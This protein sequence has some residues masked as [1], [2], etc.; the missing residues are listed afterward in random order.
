MI[1][2]N[3]PVDDRDTGLTSLDGGR[4]LMTWFSS[5]I[6]ISDADKS[7]IGRVTRR[8]RMDFDPVLST[9]DDATVEKNVGFFK[10]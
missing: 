8:Y 10:T 4:A 3:S 1:V 6:R 5:D 2:N 7:K 9:W